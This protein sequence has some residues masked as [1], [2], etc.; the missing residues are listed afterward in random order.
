MLGISLLWRSPSPGINIHVD[1]LVTLL[2]RENFTENEHF[3]IENAHYSRSDEIGTENITSNGNRAF[4]S[5]AELLSHRPRF[6]D[7]NGEFQIEIRVSKIRTFFQKVFTIHSRMTASGDHKHHSNGSSFDY[8]AMEV[9][10]ESFNF[11][12]FVWEVVLGP[13]PQL[14]TTSW[15]AAAASIASP[16]GKT[17]KQQARSRH[18]SME[19]TELDKLGINIVLV[20]K[21]AIPPKSPIT[22]NTSKNN[23]KNKLI[24][25]LS[26]NINNEVVTINDDLLARLTYKVLYNAYYI[27][28]VPKRI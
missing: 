10:S 6:V 12:G 8:E 14:L 24:N 28:W 23:A 22:G 26:I 2:N 21:S 15:A 11:G 18:E 17:L 20:R 4:I 7:T 3:R 19:N 1:L 27:N 13:Q 5:I 25:K 16:R 9:K